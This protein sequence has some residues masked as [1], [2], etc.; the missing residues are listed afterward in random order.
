MIGNTPSDVTSESKKLSFCCQTSFSLQET[1]SVLLSGG[2]TA[3]ASY[4]QFQIQLSSDPT[5][6]EVEAQ[7]QTW[8]HKKYS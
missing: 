2:L 5:A 7:V 3:E 1:F 4:V 6:F 8:E